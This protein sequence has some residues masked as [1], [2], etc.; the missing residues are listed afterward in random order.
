MSPDA[1]PGLQA[2]LAPEQPRVEGLRL[3][4]RRREVEL[5]R[6]FASSAGVPAASLGHA[7]LTAGLYRLAEEQAARAMQVAA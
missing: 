5:L 4:L 7:L 2:V 3:K 1:S 6:Q